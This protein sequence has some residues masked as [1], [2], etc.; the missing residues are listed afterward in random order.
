MAIF[1]KQEVPSNP[2]A[3]AV[4]VSS[5]TSGRAAGTSISTV[6]A[7]TLLKGELSGTSDVRLE[8]RIEGNVMLE[9]DLTV[10]SGGVVEGDIEAIA[11]KVAGEVHGNVI[12]SRAIEVLTSGILHGDLEAPNVSI[13]SGGFVKGSVSMPGRPG[14]DA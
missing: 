4:P 2:V 11:V 6:G 9:A 1:G 8:G 3:A 13:A 14:D 10:G 5:P 7:G 12:A